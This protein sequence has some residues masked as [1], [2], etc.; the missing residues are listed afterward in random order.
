MKPTL[1]VLSHKVIHSLQVI[2]QCMAKSRIYKQVKGTIEVTG[3]RR[4]WQLIRVLQ[5]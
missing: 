1:F 3:F 4:S 5:Y 2:A